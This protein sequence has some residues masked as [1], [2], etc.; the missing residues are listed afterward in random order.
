M[1][2]QPASFAFTLLL[3]F[4]AAVPYSGIDINLPAL[5]AT[6][7]TLGVSPSEVGLTMSAFMLSL[8][9][10]PLIYGPVSDRFGR[11]PVVAFGVALFVVASLACAVAQSLPALL[12]CR[13]VQGVGAASTAMTFAIIRDLFGEETARAKIANVV[14]D[15]QCGDGDRADRRRR[16]ADDRRLAADLRDPGRDRRPSFAGRDASD[17]PRAQGSIPPIAWRQRL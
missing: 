1:Q 4:L 9:V 11:K 5:A 17:L 8:A 13:F 3:G 16:A 12:V 10:A 6:G 2:I 14:V 7:A 15:Y